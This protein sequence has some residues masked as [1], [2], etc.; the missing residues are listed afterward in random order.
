[1]GYVP[2]I[3]KCRLKTGGKTIE[4]IREKNKGQGLAYRDFKNIQRAY[5]Q[6][7]DVILYLSLWDYDNYE[8]Y[9]ICGWDDEFDEKMMM[10]VYYAEQIHPFPQYKGKLQTFI[11]DWKAKRYDPGCAICFNREDVEELEVISEEV[12]E[13]AKS[14][15]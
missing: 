14:H 2:K 10:G 8:S 5:E 6:F 4:E 12:K 7:D 1:M 3:I 13:G 9:H 15:E 11:A